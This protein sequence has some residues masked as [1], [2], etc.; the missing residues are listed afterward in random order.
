MQVSEP[1]L[2][3]PHPGPLLVLQRVDERLIVED[4]TTGIRGN[5][6]YMNEV[7]MVAVR[8]TH[9]NFVWMAAKFSGQCNECKIRTAPQGEVL[10]MPGLQRIWCV[11]CGVAE[12]K[13]FVR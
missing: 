9:K 7:D 12:L 13:K 3:N 4:L 1:T 2:L 5:W 11:K 6:V 10:W 8:P